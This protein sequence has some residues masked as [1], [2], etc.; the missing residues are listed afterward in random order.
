MKS[1]IKPISKS[2]LISLELNAAVSAG[3][4]GILKKY[5]DLEQQYQ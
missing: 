4:A 5:Q 3:D 1:V 2:V